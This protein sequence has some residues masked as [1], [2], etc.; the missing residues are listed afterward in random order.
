MSV[1]EVGKEDIVNLTERLKW[2]FEINEQAIKEQLKQNVTLKQGPFQDPLYVKCYPLQLERVLDN[3]LN[4]ATN[5]IPARGGMLSI[6]TYNE[7]GWAC[8]EISNTGHISEEDRLR[9]LEGE[10]RGRGL[11]ITHRIVRLLRGKIEIRTKKEM[12][13]F[14]VRLPISRATAASTGCDV[15]TSGGAVDTASG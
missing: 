15:T 9:L 5:A 4:N 7:P 1:Y 3:L 12:T 11:H 2:R 13:T 10:G 14:V 8:A 6:S